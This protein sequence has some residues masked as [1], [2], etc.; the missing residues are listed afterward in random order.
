MLRP[1]NPPAVSCGSLILEKNKIQKE[2]VISRFVYK[3]ICEKHINEGFNH[4][5]EWLKADR[6]HYVKY[7]EYDMYCHIVE[8]I[9]DFQDLYGHFP[10]YGEMYSTLHQIMLRFAAVEEYELASIMKRWV[11]RINAII[12]S[13]PQSIQA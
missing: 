10:E 6:V 7:L 13:V 1:W 3:S 11:D 8:I 4:E 9:N 5:Q 12:H 2:L